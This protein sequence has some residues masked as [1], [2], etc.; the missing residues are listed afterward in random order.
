VQL[1]ICL[2]NTCTFSSSVSWGAGLFISFAGGTTLSAMDEPRNGVAFS[3]ML[4]D[5][6]NL[7]SKIHKTCADGAQNLDMPLTV[8]TRCI[9]LPC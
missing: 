8:R 3:A 7:A 6:G 4:V 5:E 1:E 9:R 2:L